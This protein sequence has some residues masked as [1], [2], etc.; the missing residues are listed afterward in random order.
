MNTSWD[1]VIVGA[2]VSGLSAACE[3]RKSGLSILVLEARDH[4]GG[5]AW[6]RHEPG[7]SAPIELGAEFI[8]GRVPETFELLHEV[9][10]AALDTSGAHWTLRNGRLVQNT[11]D[12]FGDI[13]NA[14]ERSKVLQKPDI[15]FQAW[16]DHSDQYGLCDEAATMAKAFV[17]GFDA[18]DP[19]RVSAHFIAREWGTGGMLDSP[20]FRPL[21][22][23]NSVLS[24][25]AGSLDRDNIQ[26]QLHSAVEEIRWQRGSAEIDV[27]RFERTTTLRATTVI[28]TL[29]LGVLQ[30]GSVRFMPA[31]DSKR[32]ALEQLVFGPVLK[33]NLRFRKAFWEELD[34]RKY[35]GASFF[36]SADT[37]FPTF[38]TTLPLRAPLMTAWVAGP[39]AAR[40]ST[41]EMPHIVR[42]ALESLATIFHGAKL[43]LEGA[44]LHNW[45]T[46]PYSL[47]AY[48]YIGVGG[49]DAR[50]TLA[51][52]L[53]DTLFFAGEATDENE[54]ATVGG[55]L[56]S[57]ARAAAEISARFKH[58]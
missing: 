19:A 39:K 44:Y 27:T 45:Q 7:L 35:A 25:L 42:Q 9:G 37:P 32:A 48:S 4:I 56:Q 13:Q 31:L 52:P 57:G 30:A 5:R 49:S 50:R 43:D 55:A 20:Q 36:H 58:G 46:D 8:H 47:G 28:V 21:G 2:G 14:L 38:W 41:Q 40:L 54:A 11:E 17:E 51:A 34:D 26:L 33:L 18:A 10:K 16:L 29:P 24:A 53:K 12:L 3:L 6:T 15:S 1:V 23:Y 22:G